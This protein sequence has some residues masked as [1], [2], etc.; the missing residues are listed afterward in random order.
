[1]Q[2]IAQ[3]P[4][5]D[6]AVV[7]SE[8]FRSAVAEAVQDEMRD[9]VWAWRYIA[10]E[11]PGE[12]AIDQQDPFGSAARAME[13][14]M[15]AA[16]VAVSAKDTS[17]PP[18]GDGAD[19]C[20]DEQAQRLDGSQA[21][22]FSEAETARRSASA[23]SG[24]RTAPSD[25]TGREAVAR[26]DA[27]AETM[28][29]EWVENN[30]CQRWR[31]L[32]NGRVSM[33][34]AEASS[35]R[36]TQRRRAQA[37]LADVVLLHRETAPADT[38]STRAQADKLFRCFLDSGNLASDVRVRELLGMGIHALSSNPP[39][40]S[41]LVKSATTVQARMTP[42]DSRIDASHRVRA[43][44]SLVAEAGDDAA[45]SIEHSKDVLYV[46][47]AGKAEVK[48]ETSGH[49]ALVKVG[50]STWSG[51][52][53][54]KRLKEITDG[55]PA[56]AFVDLHKIQSAVDL[57]SLQRCS[58][59]LLA[60]RR[61]GKIIGA[62]A[63]ESRVRCWLGM[64]FPT[65]AWHGICPGHM[66]VDKITM[67]ITEWIITTP[68]VAEFVQRH[69]RKQESEAFK[70]GEFIR[71]FAAAFD[72]PD[73]SETERDTITIRIGPLSHSFELA[74]AFPR[75]RESKDGGETPTTLPVDGADS[76]APMPPAEAPPE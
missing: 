38:P 56:D 3:F 12:P 40:V 11:D 23:S 37:L 26:N 47:R 5:A 75:S 22:A 55:I 53:P 8:A 49:L 15:D 20:D 36:A 7:D 57:E 30:K 51:T 64:A 61:T 16:G 66:S 68:K 24:L 13:G 14:V 67:G 27:G 48:G 45:K 72:T 54:H 21:G 70:L 43:L 9:A 6:D 29:Q 19:G 69:F 52:R 60:N 50:V 76:L 2:I 17:P 73:M 42:A 74:A 59:V 31:A 65:Q 58:D 34:M 62:E 4:E 39:N 71:A 41:E 1:M 46:I 35:K 28:G 10:D 44:G 25:C 33:S 32:C 18:Y 63:F